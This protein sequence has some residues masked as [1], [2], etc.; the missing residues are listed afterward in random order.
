[1]ETYKQRVIEEHKQLK[2]RAEKLGL[3]LNQYAMDEHS[4]EPNCPIELL[5]SQWH[6]MGTYLKILEVRAAFEGIELN[7]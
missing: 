6:T 5:Q 2:E 4:I 1:M 3:F 7:D